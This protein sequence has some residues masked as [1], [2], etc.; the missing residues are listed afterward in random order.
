MINTYKENVC[1]VKASLCFK[2]N[3][4]TPPKMKIDT[5][6]ESPMQNALFP[7]GNNDGCKTGRGI[8]YKKAANP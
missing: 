1:S 8:R 7:G 4:P 6:R 5:V 2:N 3:M